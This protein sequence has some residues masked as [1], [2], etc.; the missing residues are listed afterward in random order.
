MQEK[1]LMKTVSET[2]SNQTESMDKAAAERCVMIPLFPDREQLKVFKQWFGA[3]RWTYN[4]CVE[5]SR[6]GRTGTM[7]K[8]TLRDKYLNRNDVNQSKEWDWLLNVPFDIRDEAMK[9]CLNAIKSN[10]ILHK[11]DGKKWEL[12]FRTKKQKRT[13]SITINSK[14]YK[15]GGII[16]PKSFP[17]EHRQLRT[18][19]SKK[20]LLP[21]K[22]EYD[23][24]LIRNSVNQYFLCVPKPLV[25]RPDNQRSLNKQNQ[26]QKQEQEHDCI[27]QQGTMIVENEIQTMRVISL[28][29]GI[30]TFLTG[31]DPKGLVVEWGKG[32]IGRIY[33]LLMHMDELISERDQHNPNFP[34]K[35]KA[36]LHNHYHRFRRTLAIRRMQKR[37]QNLV[38]ELH[39]KCALW[40]CT[41]YDVILLPKFE[42]QSM[43]RRSNRKLNARSVRQMLTLS[44]YK[45]KMN[46][47]DKSREFP[48]V[49]VIVC[50]EHYTSKTCGQCGALNNRLGGKKEFVC[51]SC[52]SIS[53]RDFNASR[54]ILLRFLYLNRPVC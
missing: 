19:N 29:P 54:N 6:S 45:F 33:R 36:Y 52:E 30:R 26:V 17:K 37:I 15:T 48:G 51:E 47:L 41:N 18:T 20:H 49:R 12:S 7:N 14:H 10:H 46:I 31:Y 40:L 11:N 44:H 42:V 22:L 21:D 8:K 5:E 24:K 1:L 53:D 4:K 35:Q 28:D 23:S 3:A 16:F 34:R 32:D 25:I 38:S 39:R 9:E 2:Q 50:D 27:D 43:V 13:E